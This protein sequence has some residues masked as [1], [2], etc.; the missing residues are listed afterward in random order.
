[1]ASS[2]LLSSSLMMSSAFSPQPH[3]TAVALKWR[4]MMAASAKCRFLPLNAM[5]SFAL[6]HAIWLFPLP[7]MGQAE[8]TS[9]KG[10]KE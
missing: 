8:S 4:R 2:T 6:R 10:V 3:F 1:M 5:A 9:Y 7:M